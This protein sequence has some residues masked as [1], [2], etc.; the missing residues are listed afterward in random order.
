M[1]KI[2]CF[3]AGPVFKGGLANYNTSLAKALDERGD[4]EVHIVSWTQQYPSI[5]PRDFIDRKS[6]VNLLDGT[7][8]KVHYITNYNNPLTW[9]KTA[10]LIESINP[11]K[12]IF[13]W[14]I[15]IQGL[16]L[17]RIVRSL[18]KICNAE[19]IF[20]LH[21]VIQKENSS[22]DRIFTKYALSV[23]DSFIVHSGKTGKELET[24][25][26]G[27]QFYYTA[28]HSKPDS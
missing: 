21:F 7:G 19:I 24:L 22:T 14:S 10:S 18:K 25:F 9:Q 27:R 15:A 6:K 5:I 4:F 1:R 12:V 16:P 23:A 17:G 26:P 11:E 3:G 2:V 8:I 13:Q 28:R 20:D